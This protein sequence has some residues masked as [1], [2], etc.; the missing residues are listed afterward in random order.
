MRR[1][2]R[3]DWTRAPYSPSGAGITT[4]TWLHWEIVRSLDAENPGRNGFFTAETA[5]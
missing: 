3:E 2:P 5:K 1:V 4:A